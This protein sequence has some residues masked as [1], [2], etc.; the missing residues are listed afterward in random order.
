M[1]KYKRN[2]NKSKEVAKVREETVAVFGR[3]NYEGAF[4]EV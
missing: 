2:G 4:D 3:P 1:N